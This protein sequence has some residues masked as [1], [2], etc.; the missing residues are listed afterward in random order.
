MGRNEEVKVLL[1]YSLTHV[2][3]ERKGEEK[4]GEERRGEKMNACVRRI[5]MFITSTSIWEMLYYKKKKQFL[6]T[7]RV[8]AVCPSVSRLK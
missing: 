6:S 3:E 2:T 5:L 1:L 8:I 4:K 7:T